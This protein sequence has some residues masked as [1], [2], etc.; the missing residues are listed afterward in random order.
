MVVSIVS[1]IVDPEDSTFWLDGTCPYHYK[2]FPN[3][4]TEWCK[5]AKAVV[6]TST[7]RHHK[8]VVLGNWMYHSVSQSNWNNVNT[9]I[10]RIKANVVD[11][12]SVA[13]L[14]TSCVPYKSRVMSL[15]FFIRRVLHQVQGYGICWLDSRSICL[16]CLGSSSF[17]LIL[18][19]MS[20]KLTC[21]NH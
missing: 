8:I 14:L 7:A 3:C 11:T 18:S 15:T 9:I 19:V 20:V 1:K 2:S 4:P 13:G 17:L 21:F 16:F 6:Y 10:W 5:H 12:V